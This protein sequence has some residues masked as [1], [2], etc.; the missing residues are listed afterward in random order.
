[1]GNKV[2]ASLSI[3]MVVFFLLSAGIVCGQEQM[4]ARTGVAVNRRQ[5]E[6]RRDFTLPKRSF[7]LT[8][9]CPMV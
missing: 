4:M 7:G 2:L 8:F 3:G 5:R 6:I 1:M 9:I